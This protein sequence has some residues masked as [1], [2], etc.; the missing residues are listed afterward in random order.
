L[1][2]NPASTGMAAGG[3]APARA[4]SSARVWRMGLTAALTDLALYLVWVAIPYRAIHLG[5][6]PAQLG[7][8]TTISSGT[9][10]LTT[11]F[12]GR[13]SDRVPRLYLA[14]FGAIVFAAGC[15]LILRAPSLGQL[16]P[17][18]PLSGLGMGF[19][20][21][22][23]QAALADEG[24]LDELESNLGLFNV[25]WSGGKAL[26]FLVGG[27]LYA[28]YGARAIL[29]GVPI[30]MLV[31]AALLPRRQRP[32]PETHPVPGG[33]D[34]TAES[35]RL[36]PV[37]DVRALLYMAWAANAVAFGIGNTLNMQYPKFLL[38]SGRGS[39]VFGLFLGTI[40]A[41]QTLVFWGLRTRHG[42]RFRRLPVYA[43][44]A[45]AAAGTLLLAWARP[46]WLIL[47][48]AVPLGLGLG[49][50]YHASIVYSLIDRSGRGRRA[51]IHEALLGAGNF[52]LPLL[53][54]LAASAASDL[55]MP[56]LLC[57][58][59]VLVGIGAQELIWRRRA[60]TMS[61]I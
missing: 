16:F 56:Y 40:F 30:T 13:L 37:G 23:V 51:G 29:I 9:Y 10:V 35:Y 15:V 49:L 20:W 22:T 5:A 3:A 43:V 17:R 31:V 14:R 44:Q 55:R 32:R 2:K 60:T 6:G 38:Q 39:A 1:A 41:V 36:P 12:T 24:S 45:A 34:R 8:L 52:L 42:W 33:G 7:L 57:G 59:I 26:G 47:L 48:V 25:F 46:I 4:R 27:S 19:F 61:A 58:A 11:L 50:C 18:L 28:L 54:G 53:G 21:P